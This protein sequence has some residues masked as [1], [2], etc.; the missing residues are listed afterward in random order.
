M[1]IESRKTIG[2]F[3][4]VSLNSEMKSAECCGKQITMICSVG[5]REIVRRKMKVPE[6][7]GKNI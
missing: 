5:T 4:N 7:Y 3:L 2:L 1:T 6:C